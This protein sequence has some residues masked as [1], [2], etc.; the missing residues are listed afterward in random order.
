ME[1]E[2]IS[3]PT[4]A[5][6][7]EPPNMSKP[8]RNPPLAGSFNPCQAIRSSDRLGKPW[9]HAAFTPAL[10]LIKTPAASLP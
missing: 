6:C 2:P 4:R 9:N 7:F 8:L 1:L 3:K 10:V 5:F